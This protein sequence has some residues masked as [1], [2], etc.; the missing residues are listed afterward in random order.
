MAD[1]HNSNIPALSNQVAE[2]I[3]DIKE[4]LE[5]AKDSFERVFKVWS[6]S[7]GGNA[8]AKFNPAVGFNDGTY[9]YEFPTNQIAASSVIMLGNAST[10][11]WFYLNTAPPGWKVTTT[12]KGTVLSVSD[13]TGTSNGSATSTS[14]N[15]LVDSGATFYSDGVVAGDTVYNTTDSTVTTVASGYT[16]NE[17]TLPLDDDYFTSGEG[18]IVGKPYV[19]AGGRQTANGTWTQPNHTLTT[20]EIPAHSHTVGNTIG[21]G[22]IAWTAD[23]NG[24]TST[25][26][27]GPADGGSGGAHNHGTAWRPVGSIG[28]LFQLDTA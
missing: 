24:A 8:S 20:S 1:Q 2:D 12:G 7:A 11:A 6:T 15:N 14:A 5:H 10:I 28:K 17:T 9:N 23:G 4:N 22:Y 27:H 19:E 25:Q 13:T 16:T 3:P 26:E 18:Y 21:A